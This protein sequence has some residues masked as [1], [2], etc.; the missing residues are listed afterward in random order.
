MSCVSVIQR[1]AARSVAHRCAA[2]G[3]RRRA[4]RAAPA[5]TR[6]PSSRTAAPSRPTRPAFRAARG[7]QLID[8]AGRAVA[9]GARRLARR[10]PVPRRQARER[11]PDR[12]LGRGGGESAAADGDLG[13]LGAPEHAALRPAD[14]DERLR[15]SD[16]AG[17]H[18][19]RDR[20]APARRRAAAPTRRW[21]ST[22]AT[23]TP[24][25]PG[26]TAGSRR[27]RTLLGFAVVDVNMRGTGCSGGA[28]DYFEPLQSLD[29]YDVIETVA[30]QPWVLHHRVGMIG[31]SYGGISQLF[32][33]ATD[34]P[35]LA[36]IAP[37]SVI[38]NT[39]TTLYPG[40]H[41]QHRLRAVVGARSVCTTPCRRRRPAGQ[42]WALQA[43]PGR[44]RDLPGQPGPARRGRQPARQGD[45]PTP[46]T[47]R[48]SPTRSRR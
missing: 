36:A 40:G 9:V 24:T 19:A 39:A 4:G 5:R 1:R 31:I 13:P 26:P 2:R 16:H 6:M 37:L 34:P 14:A 20:R 7:L 41:P 23:A 15:L 3:V 17:R 44:R 28:F 48:R 25:R 45:A 47:C 27:S 12:A 29:G 18:D 8:R 22:P 38:D 33:A 35:D 42:A 30:H 10:D 21:S 11:L 46:T 43:D 32:V